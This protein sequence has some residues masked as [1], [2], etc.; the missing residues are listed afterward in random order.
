MA[1]VRRRSVPS[2]WMVGALLLPVGAKVNKQEVE[3][4]KCEVCRLA[5]AEAKDI[6]GEKGL[7]AKSEEVL[8]E[9]A[10]NLC[11]IARREGR[12]LRRLDVINVGDGKL[13]VKNM[14]DYG[15]C[16]NECLLV[17]RA[18]QVGLNDRQEQLVELLQQ[19]EGIEGLRKKVCKKA[20]GKPAKPLKQPRKDEEFVIGPDKGMLEMME[21]RDK[22]RAE[23]GQ[24]FDIMRRDEMDQMSVG[25]M[26]AQAAQDA[27]A[28]ELREARARSGKDWKGK[29]LEDL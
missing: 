6:Q 14:T 10:D 29:D 5:V 26:E 7:D 8:S 22:L 3:L 27:F 12:W 23:T 17:R 11:T 16:R 2:F 21:N 13:A 15:E 19:E 28:E 18:C 4:L 24:V 25:D 9:L 20:C 1:Q